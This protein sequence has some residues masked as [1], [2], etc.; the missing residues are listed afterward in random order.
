MSIYHPAQDHRKALN[1]TAAT[2]INKKIHTYIRTIKDSEWLHRRLRE[3][4]LA[5]WPKRTSEAG[6]NFIAGQAPAD[7]KNTR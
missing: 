7:P 4:G 2:R 1:T 6:M 3:L 5:G